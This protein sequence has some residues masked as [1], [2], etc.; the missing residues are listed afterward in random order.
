[1]KISTVVGLGLGA[2]I[3]YVGGTTLS[4]SFKRKSKKMLRDKIVE[5]LD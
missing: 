5:I 1:M 4:G 3:G 2:V